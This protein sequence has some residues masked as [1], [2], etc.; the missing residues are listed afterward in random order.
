MIES[1]SSRFLLLMLLL[2]VTKRSAYMN[3]LQLRTLIFLSG[4]LLREKN[5]LKMLYV[6]EQAGILQ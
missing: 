6:K 3:L 5:H 4:P 1:S 2:P